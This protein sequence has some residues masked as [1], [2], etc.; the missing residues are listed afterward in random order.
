MEMVFCCA[1][2]FLCAIFIVFEAVE[3]HDGAKAALKVKPRH[4]K[5]SSLV[6]YMVQVQTAHI[7]THSL[8]LFL[9]HTHTHT[10]TS[11]S[12]SLSLSLSVAHC[13]IARVSECSGVWLDQG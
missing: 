10:H 8:T 6:I 2:V 7:H 4:T 12:L 11:N 1:D 9:S 5:I 3:L 13:P